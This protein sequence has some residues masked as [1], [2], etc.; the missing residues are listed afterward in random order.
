MSV[1]GEK[2]MASFWKKSKRLSSQTPT[3]GLRKMNRP[4]IPTSSSLNE[5]KEKILD[6]LDH[7]QDIGKRELTFQG[8]SA[9]LVFYVP[10]MDSVKLPTVKVRIDYRGI[11]N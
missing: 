7:S 6:Y 1:G 2:R 3:E 5:N 10:L 11:T 8:K 9:L 4:V